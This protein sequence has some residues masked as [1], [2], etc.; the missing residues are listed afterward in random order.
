VIGQRRRWD[1]TLGFYVGVAFS[2]LMFTAAILIAGT[3][4]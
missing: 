2:T 4:G 1:L 3:P